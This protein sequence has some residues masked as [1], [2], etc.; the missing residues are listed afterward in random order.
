VSALVGKRVLLL[1][2]RF[3]GYHLA[4]RDELRSRGA[5]V[6]LVADRPF[7]SPLLKAATT[8]ARAAMMPLAY[9]HY[10]R[11]LLE[12]KCEPFDLVLVIVGQTVAPRLLMELRRRSPRARFVLYL[13][14]SLEN[15]GSAVRN[16]PLFDSVLSFDPDDCAQYGLTY[17]PLFYRDVS[18]DVA[19][20]AD[21]AGDV[22]S[23]RHGL[24]FVGTIHSD[25]YAVVSAVSRALPVGVQF[26]RYLYMQAPWV[27][28][29]QRLL[30]RQMRA[31]RRAE[32]E[33][34]PLLAG[35]VARVFRESFAVLDVEHPRQRGLTMRT[36]ETLGAGKKLI[37][38]NADVRSHDFFEERNILVI[39]RL[40]PSIPREFFEA[41]AVAIKPDIRYRY[42]IAGWLDAV[43]SEGRD[44]A[45]AMRSGR[46]S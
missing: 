23:F 6:E 22:R 13:W 25:R 28:Y 17:R 32:F 38:T 16:L 12:P 36:F 19:V 20:A 3:F 44:A 37:T 2:P 41:P 5:E 24:S 4:V 46:A 31:A 9:A 43:I 34:L 26:H 7:D 30:N 33:F 42:S 11:L 40:A 45:D 8:Y 15:R 14:D 35:D 1:A 10:R 21:G 29:A 18:A 39:D 27:F